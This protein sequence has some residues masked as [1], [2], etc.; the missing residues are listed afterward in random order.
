MEN[1]NDVEKFIKLANEA[2]SAD[3]ENAS[4]KFAIAIHF[5]MKKFELPQTMDQ[6]SRNNDEVDEMQKLWH[7]NEYCMKFQDIPPTI[8]M[9][10]LVIAFARYAIGYKKLSVKIKDMTI[11]EHGKKINV[12]DAFASTYCYII[13]HT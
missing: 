12:W 8:P 10:I 6:A 4:K 13:L 1:F 5:A 3:K 2:I 7:S 9:W 11:M